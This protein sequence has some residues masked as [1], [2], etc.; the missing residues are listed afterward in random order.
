LTENY[1]TDVQKAKQ[2]PEKKNST[3]KLPP[4][5]QIVEIST[6]LK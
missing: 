5:L 6:L 1:T 4:K 2:N 3:W